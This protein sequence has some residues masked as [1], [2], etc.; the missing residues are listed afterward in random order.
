MV[1][2]NAVEATLVPSSMNSQNITGEAPRLLPSS[3]IASS[4][5]QG[6]VSI[7]TLQTGVERLCPSAGWYYLFLRNKELRRY[8]DIF[9]GRQSVQVKSFPGGREE[10]RR[11]RFKIFSY[12][13]ANHKKRFEHCPY[14]KEEYRQ[15]SASAIAVR[16]AFATG[17]MDKL[18]A[19]TDAK[20]IVGDGYLFVCAPLDDLNLILGSQFPRQYLVT[21]YKGYGPALIPHRQMEEFIYLYESMPYNIELLD[22][23][24]EEY[25]QKKQRIRITGGIFRGKEGCIMRLHRNTRLVFAFG[26]M[27]VAINY[28]HAFP[29]EKI[30]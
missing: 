8:V 1:V 12:T 13:T 28:L 18:N 15:R 20:E 29:F 26:N 24:L 23:P 7:T 9:S 22:R 2:N 3:S 4:P 11:F 27:T 21:G 19:L 6:S 16:E 25:A 14:N 30:D 17:D 5:D 10:E